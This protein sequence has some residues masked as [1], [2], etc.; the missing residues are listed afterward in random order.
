[1]TTT[2]K[3]TG[4]TPRVIDLLG[5]Y[6]FLAGYVQCCW[7]TERKPD[8]MEAH[9]SVMKGRDLVGKIVSDRSAVLISAYR[10]W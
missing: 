9:S 6:V 10:L 2:T 4:F 3:R 7:S 1:M 8:L 5:Q